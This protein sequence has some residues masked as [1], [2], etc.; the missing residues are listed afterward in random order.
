MGMEWNANRCPVR[1]RS[2]NPWCDEI[3]FNI[4]KLGFHLKHTYRAL[5]SIKV[6]AHVSK[7]LVSEKRSNLKVKI[8]RNC[9]V[10][11][12]LLSGSPEEWRMTRGSFQS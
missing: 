12:G 6:D 8:L 1:S 2:P 7:R 3:A 4:S 11:V 10:E 5:D 9:V